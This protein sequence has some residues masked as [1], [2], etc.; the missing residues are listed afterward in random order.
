MVWR[1]AGRIRAV[2]LAVGVAVAA[3][4]VEAPVTQTSPSA[5]APV[6]TLE[7]RILLFA[8]GDLSEL[9]LLT[10]ATEQVVP[11]RG[12]SLGQYDEISGAQLSADGSVHAMIGRGEGE[13]LFGSRLV[14]STLLRL[15]PDAPPEQ[16][17]PDL[18]PESSLLGITPTQAV[19]SS[20]GDREAEAEAEAEAAILSLDLRSDGEAEWRTV[21]EG[22]DAALSPDGLEVAF[23]RVNEGEPSIWRVPLDGSEEPVRVSEPADLTPFIDSGLRRPT[24]GSLRWGEGG[25]AAIVSERGEDSRRFGLLL[26]GNDGAVRALPLGASTPVDVVWQPRGPLLAFTQ[27]FRCFRFFRRQPPSGELSVFDASMREVRQIAA[28]RDAFG[29][30]TWSPDG[31]QLVTQWTQ[32][33]LLFTDPAGR[34]LGRISMEA[35]P[36]DWEDTE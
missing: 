8:G 22:C 11:L 16:V 24:L 13:G 35:L 34:E 31:E 5:R 3:C 18:P 10:P 17:G 29:G 15:R 36:L 20:C 27:C 4:T 26:V 21:A 19:A 6:S 12:G 14:E 30:L 32:G 23:V 9:A 25:I 7:G 1:K 2:G 33:E 28:T